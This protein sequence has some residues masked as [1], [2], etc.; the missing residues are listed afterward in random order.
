MFYIAARPLPPHPIALPMDTWV[1]AGCFFWNVWSMSS[2]DVNSDV[3]CGAARHSTAMPR[4][5]RSKIKRTAT[6]TKK[7]KNGKEDVRGKD[8]EGRW[9]GHHGGR[10][11]Q[12][13]TV[14][15]TWQRTE[16]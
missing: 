2:F 14:T 8:K 1:N 3:E 9:V 5:K 7:P 11:S 13:R 10:G 4:V 15:Q 12:T 16:N 6:S